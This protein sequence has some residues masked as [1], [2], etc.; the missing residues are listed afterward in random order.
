M[1]AHRSTLQISAADFLPQ[2]RTI[3]ALRKAARECQGCPLYQNATQT[4]F[5][6]GAMKADVLMAGEQ[7]GDQED[8]QGR[9]F[10]GP[11]GRLLDAALDEAGIDRGEVY[12]TNAVKHFKWTPRGKKR[13]HAKPSSRE[14]TAC[15]PWLTAE[16]DAVQPQIVVCLGAT[17]AQSLLGS[18]FRITRQRGQLLDS[19]W[20]PAV[21][22]TYH[23]SAVLR[24]PEREQ[25]EEL[26]ALL[27]RDLSLVSRTLAKRRKRRHD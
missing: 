14:I 23:P 8:L 22:A 27:V 21:M 26:R 2:R 13:L 12:M 15:R 18:S 24:A 17:A 9:P 6:A 4:V 25:R 3:S 19:E 1:N 5:G 20:A 10:V 16:I 7:P 11:A